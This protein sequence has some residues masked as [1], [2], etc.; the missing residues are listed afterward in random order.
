LDHEIVAGPATKLRQGR[1][2]L[3][4]SDRTGQRAA[5]FNPTSKFATSLPVFR[6]CARGTAKRLREMALVGSDRERRSPSRR[7]ACT[8]D[9]LRGIAGTW[10]TRQGERTEC[11]G[12]WAENACG[13]RGYCATQPQQYSQYLGVGRTDSSLCPPVFGV[14]L[15]RCS[16]SQHFSLDVVIFD[17]TGTLKSR[18]RSSASRSFTHGRRR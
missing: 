12:W 14:C 9:E 8:C 7:E 16:E 10:D 6:C 17:K 1:I 15:C 11:G 18:A 3:N 4:H 5:R 2:E 13:R